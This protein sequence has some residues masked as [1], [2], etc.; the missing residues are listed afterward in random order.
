M[1]KVLIV[2]D[3]PVA[4]KIIESI[5]SM[6]K[7]FKVVGVARN[8]RE[9]VELTQSCRPDIITMDIGMPI[10]NGYEATRL[11]METCPTP[12]VIVSAYIERKDIAN[13]FKFIEAGALMIMPKPDGFGRTSF[14]KGA[15]ELRK[16][17]KLMA[18]VKVVRRNRVPER[19]KSPAKVIT[20]PDLSTKNGMKIVGIGASTGG[21]QVIKDIIEALPLSFPVPILVV[22]HMTAGYIQGFAEWINSASAL[23]VVVAEDRMECRPGVVYIAPDNYQMGVDNFCRIY[24]R[25]DPPEMGLRPSVS[26]LFRS[27]ATNFP[28][29]AVGILLTGMGRDGA[30]EL[31][32]MREAGALTVAQDMES[33]LIFGM[34]GEAVKLEAA[35]S[36]LPTSGIINLL[37]QMVNKGEPGGDRG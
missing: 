3:S 30:T 26:Y 32:K 15:E 21:P 19:E 22:Q 1:I 17:L 8:G 33:S 11:I 2:D 24:L 20:A 14:A 6:D 31:K 13:S 29:R 12:I 18:E 37:L 35:V 16:T 36:V 10:M 28:E 25:D 9:A 7:I 5:L 23:P 27:L 4:I 34:P